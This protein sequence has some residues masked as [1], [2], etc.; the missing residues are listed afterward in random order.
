MLRVGKLRRAFFHQLVFHLPLIHLLIDLLEPGQR[1]VV[2]L[3][4]QGVAQ[5]GEIT[6]EQR[7]LL[8]DGPL[9]DAR[10]ERMTANILQMGRG[11]PVPSA[12]KTV[13]GNAPALP[14]PSWATQVS[15][16]AHGMPGPA[17]V[18]QLPDGSFVV[19][20]A[21][22]H[23]IWRVDALVAIAFL[24]LVFL[25]VVGCAWQWWRLLRGTRPVVLHESE[26]V[27]LTQINPAR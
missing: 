2:L 24:L 21:R 7:G 11:L 25:I 3:R 19:A 18:A 16:L 20:D 5:E 26:F 27:S 6:R 23:R 17:G 8:V 13:T 15:T 9:R 1:L 4:L 10:I 14:D 12:L 22:A